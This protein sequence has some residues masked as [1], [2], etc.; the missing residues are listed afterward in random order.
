VK[1]DRTKSTADKLI[2]AFD[3]GTNLNPEKDMH[4]HGLRI[5]FHKDGH[6]TS[7]WDAYAGGKMA[8]TTTFEL[9]RQ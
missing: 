3:G 2:F 7:A 6:V 8:G 1:L 4:I 5:T 9:T